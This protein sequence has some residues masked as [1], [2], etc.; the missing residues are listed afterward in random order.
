[1]Q[2][3]VYSPLNV[4]LEQPFKVNCYS[5]AIMF[6]NNNNNKKIN[7]FFKK[8]H[9][10]DFYTLHTQHYSQNERCLPCNN[11]YILNTWVNS[12]KLHFLHLVNTKVII[13]KNLSL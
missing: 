1:M 10:N 7:N 9:V 11:N 12:D 2:E 3:S 4:F 6:L 13:I 8:Y 5:H